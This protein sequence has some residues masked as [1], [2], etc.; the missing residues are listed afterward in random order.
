[1]TYDNTAYL[2]KLIEDSKLVENNQE[3]TQKEK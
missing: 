3:N 1:M 2:Y